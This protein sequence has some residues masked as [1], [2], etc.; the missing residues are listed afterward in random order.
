[1]NDIAGTPNPRETEKTVLKIALF[2][3]NGADRCVGAVM[4]DEVIDLT[5]WVGPLGSC[6]L[7]AF[8]ARVTAEPPPMSGGRVPLDEVTWLPP[9]L[10]SAAPLCVGLNYLDHAKNAAKVG[11][12]GGAHPA[13]FSRYWPSL[14]GHRRPI[15]RPS[16]SKQLDVE[17]ELVVV[18]GTHCRRVPRERA[19]EVVAG[20]T[21]GQ[22]GSVRDWQRVA[23][24]PT[25]GKNFAS[26]GAMGPWMVTA[27]ELADPAELHIA[28]TVNGETVQDCDTA[29]MIYDVPML[30][31]HIT[32]FMPLAP[33]DV[34]FTGTPAGTFSDRGEQRW[35]EPGDVITI[36]IPGIGV[37]Q[38]HVVDEDDSNVPNREV[39]CGQSSVLAPR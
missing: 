23:P 16:V 36:E 18:I 38:N 24:T 30:I 7:A 2:E 5:D 3:R 39:N 31:E 29:R 32:T 9:A 12:R 17:G 11:V 20:Y 28:T 19:L 22:E 13:L 4:G 34:I 27:D 26:S 25:A 33:G 10:G 8:L 15:V 35:L 14:V 21:I 6:P 37:L 1:M